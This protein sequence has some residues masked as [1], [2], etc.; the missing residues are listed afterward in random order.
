MVRPALSPAGPISVSAPGA[1][2]V[3]LP[4]ERDAEIS[5]REP[6]YV[7]SGSTLRTHVLRERLPA[8]SNR[9]RHR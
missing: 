5:V 9:C 3:R 6:T 2:G 7:I 4:G 1:H 8:A